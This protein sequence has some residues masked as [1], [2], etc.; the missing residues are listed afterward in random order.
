MDELLE[1]SLSISIRQLN[2]ISARATSPVLGV[3]VQAFPHM[4]LSSQLGL[5]YPLNTYTDSPI[6]ENRSLNR[7]LWV[8]SLPR[9]TWC[10]LQTFPLRS[11]QPEI[12]PLFQFHVWAKPSWHQP[13][14]HLCFLKCWQASFWAPAGVWQRRL[15]ALGSVDHILGC[16]TGL[17]LYCCG[18]EWNGTFSEWMS[19]TSAAPQ[20]WQVTE[21]SQVTSLWRLPLQEQALLGAGAGQSPGTCTLTFAKLDPSRV[22]G[23]NED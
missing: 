19:S 7:R 4:L 10:L 23:L 16:V 20:R 2:N 8:F 9:W 3:G 6:E 21:P 5:L 14:W 12:H 13:G 1:L 11:P 18:L 15:Y 17:G 22:L